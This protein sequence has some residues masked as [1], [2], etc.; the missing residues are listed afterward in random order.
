M[1]NLAP[2][3]RDKALQNL[4]FRGGYEEFMQKLSGWTGA[5]P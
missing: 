1:R 2:A 5:L 4:G 3:V